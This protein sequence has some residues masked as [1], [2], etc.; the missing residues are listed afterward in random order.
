MLSPISLRLA[1]MADAR[2]WT[3]TASAPVVVVGSV[4]APRSFAVDFSALVSSDV[5]AYSDDAPAAVRSVG[6]AVS[7]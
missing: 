2:R 7:Q 5:D 3:R 6:M 4:V 1:L